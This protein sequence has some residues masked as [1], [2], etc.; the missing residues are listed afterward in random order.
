MKGFNI[1][2]DQHLNRSTVARAFPVTSF[3]QCAQ[4]CLMEPYLCPGFDVILLPAEADSP[5][6][7]PKPSTDDGGD[8]DDDDDSVDDGTKDVPY[9]VEDERGDKMPMMMDGMTI[10]CLLANSTSSVVGNKDKDVS[11]SR[12]NMA[13]MGR[14]PLA[15][16]VH[17]HFKLPRHAPLAGMYFE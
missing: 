12:L 7:V 3:S 14:M 6:I 5:P 16:P 1:Y 2:L 17:L 4:A 15:R 11:I 9:D 10:M 13:M 8:D